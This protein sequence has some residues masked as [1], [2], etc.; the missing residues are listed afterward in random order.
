MANKKEDFLKNNYSNFLSI[1]NQRNDEKKEKK[2]NLIINFIPNNICKSKNNK[3]NNFLQSKTNINGFLSSNIYLKTAENLS[4]SKKKSKEK[5]YGLITLNKFKKYKNDY[6][7]IINELDNITKIIRDKNKNLNELNNIL[8]NLNIKKNNKKNEIENNM[9]IKESL[10]DK[11]EGIIN[12][13]NNNGNDSLNINNNSYIQISLEELMLNKRE[14]YIKRIYETFGKLKINEYKN[15]KFNKFINQLISKLYIKLYIYLNNKDNKDKYDF[16]SLINNFFNVISLSITSY[17]NKL[18]FSKIIINIL[19]RILLKINIISENIENDINFLKYKY[20]EEKKIIEQNINKI[21]QEIINLS[22]KQVKLETLKMNMKQNIDIFSNK[23][24]PFYDKTIRQSKSSV[25]ELILNKKISSIIHNFKENKNKSKSL[26]IN[27]NNACYFNYSNKK[28]NF[29]FSEYLTST[30]DNNRSNS[31]FSRSKISL[32]ENSNIISTKNNKIKKIMLNNIIISKKFGYIPKNRNTDDNNK[33]KTKLKNNRSKILDTTK[34]INDIFNNPYNTKYTSYTNK[35]KDYN[36]IIKNSNFLNDECEKSK[37]ERNNN[38]KL[39]KKSIGKI[40]FKRYNEINLNKSNYISYAKSLNNIT[41][42]KKERNGN[43]L[44]KYFLI[45]RANKKPANNSNLIKD[46][47]LNFS[48]INKKSTRKINEITN[49]KQFLLNTEKS[50]RIR[51]NYLERLKINNS[52]NIYNKKNISESF[53]YYKLIEKGSNLF[54]PLSNKFN[55]NKLGYNEG[56]LLIDKKTQ[57][58]IIKSKY[59]LQKNNS[60]NMFDLK[61]FNNRYSLNSSEPLK[62]HYNQIN[63]NN[64]E[65]KDINNIYLNKNMK[66]II[67]IHKIF[68]KYNLNNN[69]EDS[70]KDNK[71]GMI[72]KKHININKIL[73]DREII[74]IKDMDQNEKIRAGLCNFFSFIIEL[75]NSKKIEFIFINFFQFNIWFNY[76]ENIINENNKSKSIN[77]KGNKSYIIKNNYNNYTCLDKERCIKNNNIIND[78]NRIFKKFFSEKNNYKF[79]EY[80][81]T[82]NI[83]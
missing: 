29:N 74:N 21:K 34:N 64:I 71:D 81:N 75:D 59:L 54:N 65:L 40:A 36:L 23:N 48:K 61:Y 46:K 5:N 2:N 4:I 9:S 17:K 73:N 66:N 14:S 55:P 47:S 63:N 72:Q 67:K 70:S 7:K 80:I 68:L 3:N 19:L 15:I 51:N 12:E 37:T 44:L 79:K 60:K 18:E 10:E 62:F 50:Y 31:N 49:N 13:I 32:N 6:K 77:S 1:T 58:L 52:K 57:S 33:I 39:I 38:D 43:K 22:Q 26:S 28:K 35:S 30:T 45:K 24:T 25:K 20:E 56:F 27:K 41:T 8:N 76:L 16:T 83:K 11:I 53:C 69:R 82:K 78:N 42:S